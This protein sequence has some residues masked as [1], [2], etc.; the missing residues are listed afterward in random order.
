[1]L[2][3]GCNAGAASWV[4]ESNSHHIRRLCTPL[5]CNSWYKQSKPVP[6]TNSLSKANVNDQRKCLTLLLASDRWLK[7]VVGT[8]LMSGCLAGG[9]EPS[10][11][12]RAGGSDLVL[13][14]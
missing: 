12:Q 9:T 11:A 5:H 14:C 6:P 7:L 1:M 4:G 3:K 10:E 13:C 8:N 2:D